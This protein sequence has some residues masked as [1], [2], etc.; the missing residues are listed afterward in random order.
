MRNI[1]LTVAYD[2]TGYAGFQRQANAPTIQATL[3]EALQDLAGEQ[4]VLTGAGRTD[5]GVHARGQVVN[6]R[7][8]LRLEVERFV[9]ALNARLPRDIAVLAAEEAAEDF[10]ARY[11]AHAKTYTYRIWRPVVR[12]VFERDRA[13]HFSRP[14]DRGAMAQAAAFLHGRQ[15]LACFCSAGSSV[16]STVRTIH[17][18]CWAGEGGEILTFT[19]SADGF[20]YRMVRNIVGTLLEIGLGKH[21]PDWVRELVAGRSRPAAGPAV[22]AC[23]LYLDRVE[24]GGDEW[25]SGGVGMKTPATMACLE[26]RIRLSP[27]PD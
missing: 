15:D 13:Y 6:F 25:G 14:L 27:V 22:P 19:I 11:S 26:Q 7:T 21:P 1:K 5:A 3:E 17:R 18:A 4:I 10:H 12:P 20:L 23:G 9:P 2:G 8:D 24:Y 16:H